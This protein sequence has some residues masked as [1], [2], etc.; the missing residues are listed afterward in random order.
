MPLIVTL[1]ADPSIIATGR[2]PGHR[3]IRRHAA[4]CILYCFNAAS[5][6]ASRLIRG[7]GL[8]GVV[9]DGTLYSAGEAKNVAAA[10]PYVI[11]TASRNTVRRSMWVKSRHVNLACAVH[12]ATAFSIAVYHAMLRGS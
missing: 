3:M 2:R 12:S 10:A 8:G 5:S 1:M 7:G 11:V 9:D 4:R 6:Q